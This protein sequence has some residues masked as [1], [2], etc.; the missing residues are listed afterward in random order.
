MD[1]SHIS[2]NPS[3]TTT[4]NADTGAPLVD[5]HPS[6]EAHLGLHHALND[7]E[8]ESHDAI[9]RIRAHDLARMI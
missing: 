2:N 4:N 7:R 9:G 3:L 5:Q 8:D 1:N 6:V